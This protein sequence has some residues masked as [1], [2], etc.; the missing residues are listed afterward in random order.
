VIVDM[1]GCDTYFAMEDLDGDGIP[2]LVATLFWGKR[3]EV[4][5]TDSTGRFDDASRLTHT[6]VDRKVGKAFG[7][8]FADV[9]GDGQKVCVVG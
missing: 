5:S 4:T 8:E 7:L 1:K 9:N 3:V 2:E 6:V